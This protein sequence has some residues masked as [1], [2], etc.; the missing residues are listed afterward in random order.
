MALLLASL[1]IHGVSPGPFLINQHPD[2]FWSVIASMYIGNVM[3]LA[4]NL[5]L[6]GFWVQVLKIPYAYFFPIIFL[7]CL[8]GSYSIGTTV[9]DIGVMIF[10]GIVGFLMK[11]YAYESTPLILAF[12]LGPM[13]EEHFRRSLVLSFGSFRIFYERPI[14]AIFLG[15]AI[16]LLFLSLVPVFTRRKKPLA[17]N[18]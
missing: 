16:L 1:M 6:V 14:S 10:F 12:I 8:L 4:L 11:K 7:F 17:K 5:P 13:F 18:D 2:I 3:L 15:L 9:F